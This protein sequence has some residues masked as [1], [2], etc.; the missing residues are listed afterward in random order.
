MRLSRGRRRKSS[1]PRISNQRS[2]TGCTLVKKR[3]PPMSKRQPSRSAVRLIPPT[4]VSASST[5]EVT[6]RL[7]NM[8]AAVRPAGPA[9]MMSTLG[10]DRS[11]AAGAGCSVDSVVMQRLRTG[12][13]GG[14]AASC[15]PGPEHDSVRASAPDLPIPRLGHVDPEEAED[16]VPD[17]PGRRQREHRPLYVGPLR[18]ERDREHER[19]GAHRVALDRVKV[20][21]RQV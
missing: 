2:S 20:A 4:T 13:Q 5:V 15:A 1:G 7:F 10:A 12:G 21:G 17:Q 9:P 3:W 16:A 14:P 19:E 11:P 8:Y 18:D 6:P